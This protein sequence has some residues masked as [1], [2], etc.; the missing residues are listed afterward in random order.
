MAVYSKKTGFLNHR[1]AARQR[2]VEDFKW[3]ATLYEI[4]KKSNKILDRGK[5][6]VAEQFGLRNP[7]MEST[8]V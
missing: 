8:I 7:N 2:V 1:V 4:K 5:K 6:R 3:V